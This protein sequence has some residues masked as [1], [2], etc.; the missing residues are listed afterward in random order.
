[1]LD[2]TLLVITDGRR[3]YLERT[4]AS[5]AENLVTSDGTDP[6]RRRVMVDDS[7]DQAYAQWLDESFG[8]FHIVHT[9][10]RTGFGAAIQA[11]WDEVD[12]DH[13]KTGRRGTG[14]VF[15]LEDDFT[16]NRPVQLDRLAALLDR[17][18]DIAQVALRRQPWND[19][20]RRAGGIIE[21][22]PDAYTETRD[23]D[24]AWLEHRQFWTTNPSLYRTSLIARGWP[25]G[26]HSE[27]HFGIGLCEDPELRFAYWGAR[28]DGPWVEHIG[29]ER[30][31][32][33]Y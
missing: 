25:T 22:H 3:Q 33:G 23:G 27:G 32:T 7:G 28:S 4:L 9:P 10:G 8:R 1:M 18:A 29:A 11:G 17:R 12:A 19:A 5:A 2:V 31:G 13:P 15:H 16:F 24:D 26:D 14:F 21:Q 30:A 20:E 6:I